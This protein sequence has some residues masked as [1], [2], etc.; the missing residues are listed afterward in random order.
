ML[1]L[2]GKDQPLKSFLDPNIIGWIPKTDVPVYSRQ[3]LGR[4]WNGAYI[5]CGYGW[6]Q[7]IVVR[8]IG[9]DKL[10]ER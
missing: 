9:F 1:W 2:D 8:R 3:F 5:A 6:V 10:I 7:R 4:W